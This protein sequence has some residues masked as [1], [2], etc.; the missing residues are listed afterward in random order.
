M[1]AESKQLRSKQ[2]AV[3]DEDLDHYAAAVKDYVDQA[4]Q[5]KMDSCP[6]DFAE[7]YYRH[8]SAWADE[9]DTLSAHPHIRSEGE[10][11]VE[12]F[13][14]GLNGDVTGGAIQ[15]HDELQAWATQVKAAEDNVH[16]T[17]HEVEALVVRYDAR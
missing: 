2:N 14:R 11:F 15:M 13:F 16:K 8:V 9:A 4:R 10:A 7:A 17:W 3:T 5:I 1:Q 12:G 6:R